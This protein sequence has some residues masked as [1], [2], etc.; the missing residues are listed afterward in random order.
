MVDLLNGVADKFDTRVIASNK[1]G[2][3]PEDMARVENDVS[4]IS[5]GFATRNSINF[6][7]KRWPSSLRRL[8]VWALIICEPL[9]FF[10]NVFLFRHFLKNK[11]PSLVVACNGGYPAS[12]ACLAIIVASKI[13]SI[14][15]V[16]SVVSTPVSRRSY[17]YFY[18]VLIDRLVWW[19]VSAVVVNAKSISSVLEKSRGMPPSLAT[20]IYNGIEDYPMKS[21]LGSE[22]EF[23]IG[24]VS[25]L[26]HAKGC[27]VLLEAFEKLLEKYSD[28]KLVLAG[29]GD[30]SDVMRQRIS[31]KGLE[32]RVELLGHFTGSVGDLLPTFNVYAFPSFWEGFPYSIIEALRSGC[33]IVATRVGGVPEAITDGVDGILVEPRSAEEIVSGVIR[34][35]ETPGLSEELSLNAR[36]KFESE[37]SLANMHRQFAE[38]V[39]SVV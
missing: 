36:K 39:V 21:Q 34:I 2:I 9:L 10:I 4:Y 32:D 11:K 35:R 20:I 14:P 8:L 23:I 28:L 25:R 26:D 30:A 13:L 27:L 5:T 33:V 15:V 29:E 3:F 17:L 16:M 22:D 24:C 7:L 6:S 18:D 12:Q 31:E 19:G 38:L 37:L 1:G